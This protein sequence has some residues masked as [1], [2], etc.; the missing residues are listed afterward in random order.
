MSQLSQK[1]FDDQYAS[2]KK[3]L[4]PRPEDDEA[5]PKSQRKLMSETKSI[6]ND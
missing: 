3:K 5:L 2:K 6:S 1:K 4:N